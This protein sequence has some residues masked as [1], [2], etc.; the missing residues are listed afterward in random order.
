MWMLWSRQRK[1]IWQVWVETKVSVLWCCLLDT[2]SLPVTCLKLKFHGSS[3]LVASCPQQVMHV[4]LVEF[5]ERHDTRTNGQCC[6]PQ[7][8]AGR[9]ITIAGHARHPRENVTRK[10]LPWNSSFTQLFYWTIWFNFVKLWNNLQESKHKQSKCICHCISVHWGIHI[11]PV[12]KMSAL[13]SSNMSALI[14]RLPR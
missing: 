8:T 10:L 9:P 3:F 14:G 12:L 1:K 7:Q 5:G 4:G 6:T 2:Y 11:P 13:T